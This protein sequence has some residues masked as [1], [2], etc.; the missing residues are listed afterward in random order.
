[1]GTT[2][3]MIRR[4]D[5]GVL[6]QD[7]GPVTVAPPMELELEE[8]RAVAFALALVDQEQ[9]RLTAQGRY[10]DAEECAVERGV[11]WRLLTRLLD[12]T[13]AP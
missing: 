13:E 4:P 3:A 9:E 6:T 7:L 5:P 1:M 12:L 11:I 10:R 8:R 2:D